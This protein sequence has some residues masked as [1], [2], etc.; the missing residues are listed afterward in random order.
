MSIIK[1]K[2]LYFK[3]PDCKEY[4]IR[5][6][7]LTIKKNLITTIVGANGIGKSTLLKLI[8]GLLTN[9][10]GEIYINEKE[11]KNYTKNELAKSISIL[12]SDY[13]ILYPIKVI[14]FLQ[15]ARYP[16][17]K[18]LEPLTK[19]DKEFIYNISSF[20]GIT[21]LLNK[22][23]LSLSSGEKQLVYLSHI[24]VQDTPIMLLDEPFSHLDLRHKI[25]IL[26]ILKKLKDKSIIIVTHNFEYID[27]IS[28]EVILL[29][30]MKLYKKGNIKKILTKKN[31]LEIFNIYEDKF[32]NYLN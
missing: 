14:E 13:N 18:K 27:K 17:L 6:L 29:K 21:H 11:V 1:I 22:N 23:I 25:L 5:N 7:N 2:N 8:A 20:T 16:Y 9:Y 24:L 31:I 3:Y 4:L 28:N 15:M 10:K 30:N 26:D 32:R 12:F 19:M